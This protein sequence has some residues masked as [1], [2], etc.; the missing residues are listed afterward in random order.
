MNLLTV[1]LL[2]FALFVALRVFI[3]FLLI[4]SKGS[5]AYKAIIKIIPPFEFILW[6][7]YV[8]WAIYTIFSEYSFMPALLSAM[9]VVLSVIIGWYVIRD[10]VS[11][12]VIKSENAFE[13]GQYI[14]TE[15]SEGRIKK[16]GYLTLEL[17]TTNGEII[18]I[19]YSKLANQIL[20]KPDT[21][22]DNKYALI[23]LE[24]PKLHNHSVI[25]EKLIDA[26]NS[27]PW[28]I[29][30]QAPNIQVKTGK[31]NNLIAEI[32][33]ISFSDEQTAYLKS[34]L[35]EYIEKQLAE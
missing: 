20:I 29:Y 4:V 8:F 35:E 33:F 10:I 30:N 25:K 17:E 16:L 9:G 7:A 27:T 24:I 12:V 11:G 31:D 5:F 21:E 1:F 15:L 26:M 28:V 2:G 23:T 19:P 34:F 22:T 13:T 18:K 3:Y 32:R 6:A 14:K